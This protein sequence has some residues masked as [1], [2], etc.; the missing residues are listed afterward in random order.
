M[1]NK[2]EYMINLF[3]I[4]AKIIP[5]V[6][7]KKNTKVKIKLIIVVII[8]TNSKKRYLMNSINFT[9]KKVSK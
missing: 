6:T 7:Q 1:N 8:N 5:I 4:L 3:K 2:E 9:L